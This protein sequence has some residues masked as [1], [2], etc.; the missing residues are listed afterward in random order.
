MKPVGHSAGRTATAAAA[1][2]AGERIRDE[3]TGQL[4]DYSQRQDVLHTEIM[5]PSKFDGAEM[6]WARS[7]AALWNEAERAESRRDSRVAREFQVALPHELTPAQR[8]ELAREFSRDVADRYNVAVDLAIHE[9]RS[10]SDPRNYHAHLL[11]TTRE[12]TPVGLGAKTGMDMDGGARR[13]RGLAGHRA[14]LTATRER[15]ETFANE[16]LR[17]AHVVL[18][19]AEPKSSEEIRRR[20]VESWR[21]LR[22]KQAEK[23]RDAAHDAAHDQEH[24]DAHKSQGRTRNGPDY[25]FGL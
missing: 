13:S 21:Q 23:P 3:R 24:R 19:R 2:R 22:S 1:Y 15:W 12:I 8:L 17:A 16:A 5:L 20:A 11:M 6:S 14:E 10:G 18:E 4:F 25:D 9:P 7:R